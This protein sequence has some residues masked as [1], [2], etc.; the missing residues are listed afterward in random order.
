V[1]L[2]YGLLFVPLLLDMG[3]VYRVSEELQVEVER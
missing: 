2:V 1:A 3:L